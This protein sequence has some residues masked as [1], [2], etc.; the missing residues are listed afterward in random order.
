MDFQT[1]PW[2]KSWLLG[3]LSGANAA[4]D[5]VDK[6]ATDPLSALS[7]AEQAFVWVDNYCKK[8]PLEMVSSAG[9]FL[10]IELV[11]KKRESQ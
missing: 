9:M 10:M 8:N 5:G 1:G 3:Y 6:P 11:K 4:W 7:S 2:Q